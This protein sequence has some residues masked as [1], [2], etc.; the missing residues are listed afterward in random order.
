MR[1]ILRQGEA[2]FT[3]VET[4]ISLLVLGIVITAAL[5]FFRVQSVVFAAGTERATITQN[6]L[7]AATTLSRD[8]RTTGTNVAPGQPFLVYA[9]RDVIAVNADYATNVA[10]D[11][12]AVYHDPDAPAG[13]V[14]APTAASRMT[15]PRSAFSYPDTTYRIGGGAVSPAELLVFYFEPDTATVRPDDFRLYRQVNARPPELVARNLLRVAGQPFFQYLRLRGARGTGRVDSVNVASLPLAHTVP[16]H[17]S[18]GDT[19]PFAQIDSLRGVRIRLAATNGR[20]GTD[21]RTQELDQVA[22]FPNAGLTTEKSCGSPPLF[23]AALVA[24]P[25]LIS[26]APEVALSWTPA[27]DE[28]GGE[29]DVIRYV[30]WKSPLVGA[31]ST[32][33][34]LSVPAG[35]PAYSFVDRDV[36]RGESYRYSVAAQ[37]CT[38]SLSS[39][40]AAVATVP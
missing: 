30:L 38:P 2:G 26:G 33:P 25:R 13:S 35:S 8:L 11:P 12:F 29:R 32:E 40:L 21:E 14:V 9:G 17:L 36:Q 19:M 18:A 37:D 6:L 16:M 7:Y 3:L 23:G 1:R 4:L 34:F 20:A 39:V 22:W 27:T 24:V 28:T 10:N 15:I 31:P 5:D